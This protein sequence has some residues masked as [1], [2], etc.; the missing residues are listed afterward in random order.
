M[1][2]ISTHTDKKAKTI[3]LNILKILNEF[4][5]VPQQ[6]RTAQKVNSMREAIEI[7]VSNNARF[8]YINFNFDKN[9]TLT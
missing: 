8:I 2:Q 3:H 7:Q 5:S 9:D 4:V 6:I 1:E